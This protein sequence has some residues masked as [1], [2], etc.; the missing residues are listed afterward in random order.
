MPR[1]NLKHNP[2]AMHPQRRYSGVSQEIVLTDAEGWES[3]RSVE[4]S[5]K[6]TANGGGSGSRRD[7]GGREKKRRARKKKKDGRWLDLLGSPR[8]GGQSFSELPWLADRADA[9]AVSSVPAAAV[10]QQQRALSRIRRNTVPVSAGGASVVGSDGGG[11]GGGTPLG[12]RGSL[13]R[14]RSSDVSGGGFE[15]SDDSESAAGTTHDEEDDEGS[16]AAGAEDEEVKPLFS[17]EL[18]VDMLLVSWE[19]YGEEPGNDHSEEYRGGSMPIDTERHGFE[20]LEVVHSCI[21][22][23][24]VSFERRHPRHSHPLSYRYRRHFKCSACGAEG[25]MAS[26]ARKGEGGGGDNGGGGGGGRGGGGGMCYACPICAT[27]AARFSDPSREFSLCRAC[28]REGLLEEI[29]GLKDVMS[30]DEDDDL[31]AAATAANNAAAASSSASVGRNPLSP[32]NTPR[33][34]GEGAGHA[35]F[36]HGVKDNL[37]D[38]KHTVTGQVS[39]ARNRA[40]E[41]ATKMSKE[42]REMLHALTSQEKE[43][44]KTADLQAIICKGRSQIVVAFRGTDN[45]QNVKTDCTMYREIVDEM[46]LD[47][48]LD[49]FDVSSWLHRMRW[50]S[51][52]GLP[53]CHKGFLSAF[54]QIGPE[55]MQRL[56]PILE[57]HPTY[58]IVCTGHSLGGALSVLLSYWVSRYVKRKPLVYTFGSPRIGNSTFAELVDR[59]V[60]HIFRVVNACDVIPTW[61]IRLFGLLFKH[62]GREVCIDKTGNLIIEPTFIERFIGP[63]KAKRGLGFI[64]IFRVLYPTSSLTDHAMV[65]YAKSLTRIS[66]YF[67]ATDC[68]VAVRHGRSSLASFLQYRERWDPKRN[69]VL[70]RRRP[71]GVCRVS[72][73]PHM[74]PDVLETDREAA[75]AALRPK[76]EGSDEDVAPPKGVGAGGGSDPAAADAAGAAGAGAAGAGGTAGTTSGAVASGAGTTGRVD[77]ATFASALDKKDKQEKQQLRAQRRMSRERFESL[78]LE[79]LA[80]SGSTQCVGSP[81]GGGVEGT[82]RL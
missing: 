72:G 7:S 20:L 3:H 66:D 27:A 60:P 34:R 2:A 31:V 54:R 57:E 46:I 38:L 32:G 70:C 61:P 69:C 29:N 25:P 53:R 49:L 51:G 1:G 78:Q 56:V 26:T 16:T 80:H 58:E 52:V 82:A 55:V 40:R 18:C 13:L 23:T 33:A 37:T 47:R 59:A 67:C 48:R 36:V 15:Y 8:K 4:S 10:R 14:G 17:L 19:V 12:Q 43:M 68:R 30:G 28:F 50:N 62:V 74:P 77:F 5:P 44:V 79:D 71:R 41:R 45:M 11:G 64:G 42:A 24:L 81:A 63:T 35:S 21:D 22:G 65:R 73:N 76:T 6:A 9:A 39:A 75:L